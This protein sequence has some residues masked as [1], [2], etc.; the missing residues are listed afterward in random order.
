MSRP[1]LLSRVRRAVAVLA[2]RS[3]GYAA[4]KAT[5][6]NKKMLAGVGFSTADAIAVRQGRRLAGVGRELYRNVP[7]AKR[8]AKH[9]AQRVIGQQGIRPQFE[10]DAL[11]AAFAAWA[12]SCGLRGETWR[13][14]Q[15]LVVLDRITAGNGFAYKVLLPGGQMTLGVFEP[16]QLVSAWSAGEDNVVDGIEFDDLARPVAYRVAKLETGLVSQDPTRYERM[17]ADRVFHFFD[18]DRPSAVRGISEFATG[19]VTLHD[20]NDTVYAELQSQRSQ[21]YAGLHYKPN[22]SEMGAADPAWGTDYTDSG[23]TGQS[24]E[25]VP[26]TESAVNWA[27]GS[28]FEYDGDVKLLD[29]N[30]PGGQFLPFVDWLASSWAVSVGLPPHV[31]T[32]DYSKANYSSLRAAENTCRPTFEEFQTEL[33]EQVLRP[34]VRAWLEQAALAGE[35]AL[36]GESVDAIMRALDWQRPAYPF[37]DPVKDLEAH[38]RSVSLGVATFDQLCAALGKDGRAQRKAIARAKQLDEQYQVSTPGI[39]SAKASAVPEVPPP[40]TAAQQGQEAVA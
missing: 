29:S 2:G 13:A 34:M 17:T 27:P 5:R 25:D 22:P 23:V 38:E 6:L 1:G 14:I 35:V 36:R 31:I 9:I 11:D 21:A 7:A 16:E 33:I 15:K 19:A 32:G 30:R 40:D 20:M 4:G 10:D 39:G 26:A 18:R 12:E 28:A 3:E 24:G 37:V 8:A